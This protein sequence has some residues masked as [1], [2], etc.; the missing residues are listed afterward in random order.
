MQLLSSRVDIMLC[1]YEVGPPPQPQFCICLLIRA[2][3]LLLR[4]VYAGQE[5][6]VRTGHGIMDSS[7]LGKEFA[8]AVYHHA[9]YLTYM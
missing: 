3:T 9:A 2:I 1:H 6:T 4:N 8:K 5:A 7:R